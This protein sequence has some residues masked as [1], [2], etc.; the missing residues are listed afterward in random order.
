MALSGRCTASVVSGA[1]LLLVPSLVHPASRAQHP[2]ALALS[3]DTRL[4]VIAPHP[5]DETLGAGGL[6]QRVR[7]VGGEVHVVYLTDGEGYPEGVMAEDGVAT[8]TSNE[9]RDYGR[10]RRHE[11]REALRSLGIKDDALTFL[12]FPNG[13]LCTLMSK[14]W[15]RRVY[16]SP[17]TRRDRPPAADVIVRGAEYR[18]E[19]LTQELALLI[20]R[21]RPTMILVPRK[22]D[23]HADHCAAWFF[24]ADALTDVRRVRPDLRID[25][26]N[27]II[28]FGDWPFEDD[29]ER[30]LLAPAG[31][32]GGASGWIRFPLTRTELKNKQ[33]ALKQYE[34]QMK[35]MDWFLDGFARTNEIFS[36]PASSSVVLPFRRSPCCD[37]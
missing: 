17:F 6:M 21:L 23:Q 20:D 13:G 27:Y 10:R 14:Y 26:V 3:R 12:S 11:A 24:V 25:V 22:E 34:S 15:S 35:V 29:D 32:R 19:D 37:R 31:L 36:R 5:D 28:H 8:P 16:R 7:T 2:P 1:L 30:A 9:Y 18:G 4:M 33:K